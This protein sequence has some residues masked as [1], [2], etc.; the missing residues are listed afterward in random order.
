VL[1]A[2]CSTNGG[3]ITPPA[4]SPE[5]AAKKAIAEYDTN[6]DGFLSADELERCPAL[7]N[8]LV[9]MDKN[10]DGKLS[11]EE[12]ADRLRLYNESKVGA[13]SIVVT[14]TL[15][16][17]PLPDA[18][19]TF[20]PEK[21]LGPAFKPAS[22]VTQARGKAFL[23]MEGAPAAGLPYGLYRIE[24]SRKGSNGEELPA[25]YNEKSVLGVELGPD[26]ESIRAGVKLALNSQ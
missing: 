14:V 17:Q 20:I 19:V 5:E 4:L 25:Q 21:F 15:D 11:S 16:G 22:G 9:T 3:P 24:V 8:G 1:F 26:S 18:T 7:K 13:V 10:K 6:H 2:G 12:I 23:K